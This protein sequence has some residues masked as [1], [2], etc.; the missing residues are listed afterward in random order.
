MIEFE[1]GPIICNP[2]RPTSEELLFN[3]LEK[4]MDYSDILFYIVL[5]ISII[6]MF[7][8]LKKNRGK[9]KTGL[10][11]I[12]LIINILFVILIKNGVFV[13][14]LTYFTIDIYS[15]IFLIIILIIFLVTS[16]GLIYIPITSRRKQYD[17]NKN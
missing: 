5:I 17:T 13:N 8:T 16:I 9:V 11:S 15:N 10:Y 6:L 1:N 3:S 2:L 12:L 4:I 7:D 14:L